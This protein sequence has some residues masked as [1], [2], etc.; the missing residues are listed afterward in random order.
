M[1][2]PDTI[3]PVSTPECTVPV[4]L[5]YTANGSP[6]VIH[7]PA[8]YTRLNGCGDDCGNDY[9]DGLGWV[10]FTG[11]MRNITPLAWSRVEYTVY[12]PPVYAEPCNTPESPVYSEASE[13]CLE[14]EYAPSPD[15]DR[16]KQD[17]PF[18][19]E[20]GMLLFT[21]PDGGRIHYV[22]GEDS[23]GD[24]MDVADFTVRYFS[25]REFDLIRK[26]ASGKD[27]VTRYR[28]SKFAQTAPAWAYTVVPDYCF[29]H[30]D[31]FS[32]TACRECLYSKIKINNNKESEKAS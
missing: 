25:Q 23:H 1:V 29:S 28:M 30:C 6:E 15:D 9:G 16:P 14:R 21:V 31:H 19:T 32:C 18:F 3:P 10:S 20:D 17:I 12:T 26:S 2:F 5:A 24:G 11:I 27:C 7:T 13:S 4:M 22:Y 8:I